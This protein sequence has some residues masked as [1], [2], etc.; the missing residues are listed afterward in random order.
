MENLDLHGARAH[1]SIFSH[2]QA[3]H[4]CLLGAPGN[5]SL[6]ILMLRALRGQVCI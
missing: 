5:A 3:K 1:G 2:E 6:L 4:S